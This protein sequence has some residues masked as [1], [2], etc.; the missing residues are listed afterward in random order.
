MFKYKQAGFLS[1]ALALVICIALL[2]GYCSGFLA[3]YVPVDK[4]LLPFFLIGIF[5]TPVALLVQLAIRFK[6][7]KKIKGINWDEERRLDDIVDAK[8][9]RLYVLIFI[10]LI[11]IVGVATLFFM[12]TLNMP[13]DAAKWALRFSGFLAVV[14]ISS[15]LMFLS[16]SQKIVDYEARVSRRNEDR[17]RR[18]ALVKRL[19]PKE[20]NK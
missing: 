14:M 1:L 20:K 9:L 3:A 6:D 16:E 18:A 11:S 15:T 17:K 2:A 5:A 13:F 8:A 10:Y 7:L 12:S 19:T 4:P